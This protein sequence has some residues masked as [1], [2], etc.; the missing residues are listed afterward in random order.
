MR[1][2]GLAS[3]LSVFLLAAGL[4]CGGDGGDGGGSGGGE[5]GGPAQGPSGGSGGGS[6]AIDACAL[7]TKAEAEAL[8]GSASEDPK[9]DVAGPFQTCG[10]YSQSGILD[11]VQVQYCSSCL[12]GGQFDT[13]MKSGAQALGIEAKPVSGLG[14]KAYWL[15]GILWVQKGRYVINIWL[16]T[17]DFR[18]LEGSALE[19]KALP[20]HT[21]VARKVLTRIP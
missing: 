9:K 13:S 14:D 1:V 7:I 10:Y 6:A 21:D 8:L 11:F 18:G 3:C 15:G 5:S 4:A 17:P 19:A 2:R 16:A 12:P 20:V